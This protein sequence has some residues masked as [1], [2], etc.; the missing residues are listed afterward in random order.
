MNHATNYKQS[1][2]TP[3][4]KLFYL[5]LFQQLGE[6]K[7]QKVLD[8]GSGLGFTASYFAANNEVIAIEPDQQLIEE[9]FQDHHYQQLE[10]SIDQLKKLQSESI[11]LILCHNVLEYIDNRQEVIKE[12]NRLLKK[13]G[14]LSIINHNFPGKVM[15][16]VI[17]DY[18]LKE[19]HDLL[20]TQQSTLSNDFGEL[21][22][23]SYEELIS[24]T[25][26]F[27][28]MDSRM[29]IRTFYGLQDN[30]LKDS[31]DWLDKMLEM[32]LMVCKLPEFYNI[33]FF[34]HYILEK[35]QTN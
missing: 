31:A 13:D 33:S 29:G 12:F 10:G 35:T 2:D 3:W 26:P 27:L 14:R 5:I 23:V 34:N 4:G 16:K 20:N 17:C 24:L 1:L 6:V 15:A 19:A 7:S 25:R 32:E 8:F 9:R 22:E 18:N 11:D 28:H 30:Q 21:R